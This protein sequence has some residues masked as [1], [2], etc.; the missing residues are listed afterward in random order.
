MAIRVA[1]TLRLADRIAAGTTTLTALA[2]AAADPDAPGRLL[3]YLAARDVFTEPE[4]GRFALTGWRNCSAMAIPTRSAPG[5]TSP[6][7]SAA[8]MSLLLH[9]WTWCAPASRVTPIV[10]GLD[11]WADLASDPGLTASF[12]A[13]MARNSALWAPWLAAQD[14]S[15]TQHAVRRPAG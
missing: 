1:A 3:R 2:A 7:P 12:D 11:F 10:H 5:S 4:P 15:G 8:P 6:A 13:L 9:C 14:W